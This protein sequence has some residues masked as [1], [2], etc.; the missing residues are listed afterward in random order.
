MG[1]V[2]SP[3]HRT[4]LRLPSYIAMCVQVIEKVRAAGYIPVKL[5]MFQTTVQ[6]L[7][8]SFIKLI[9]K[10]NPSQRFLPPQ[11]L[12]QT[13]SGGIWGSVS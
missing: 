7:K 8:G 5:L 12:V 3:L 11:V 4:E 10:Q 1:K 6:L 2:I 9:K 13:P